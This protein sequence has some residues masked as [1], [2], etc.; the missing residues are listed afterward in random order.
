MFHI[1]VEQQKNLDTLHH[2]LYDNEY[3][4][5]LENLTM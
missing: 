1:H 5:A 4:G 2:L 3:V